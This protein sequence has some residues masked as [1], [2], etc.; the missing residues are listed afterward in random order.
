MTV[1]YETYNSEKKAFFKKHHNDFECDTS[2]MDEYGRY[3]KTY[4]F[5]DNAIWYEVMSPEYVSQEI[6][7]KMCKVTVE[8]K[9]FRTEYFN[10]DDAKSRYYYEKF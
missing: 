9:M 4:T 7:V 6:E 8:V 10:T 5:A 3:Y 1:N 2:S